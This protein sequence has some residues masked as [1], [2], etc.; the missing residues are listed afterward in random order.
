VG[1]FK[2]RFQTK[3]T[4]TLLLSSQSSPWSFLLIAKKALTP[5]YVHDLVTEMAGNQRLARVVTSILQRHLQAHSA[6]RV[7][8][9]FHMSVTANYLRR[10]KLN[11]VHLAFILPS[12]IE[13]VTKTRNKDSVVR[14]DCAMVIVHQSADPFEQLA[15]ILLLASISQQIDLSSEAITTILYSIA[16]MMAELEHRQFLLSINS[17]LGPQGNLSKLPEPVLRRL[18]SIP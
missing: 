2:Q 11:D 17:V 13:G 9:G 5:L 10:I 14:H 18:L 16:E 6:H 12:L 3:R 7:V 1:P 8:I 15:N 4:D